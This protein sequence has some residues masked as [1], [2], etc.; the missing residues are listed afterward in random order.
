MDA[1]Y[2]IAAKQQ[3]VKDYNAA[4]NT[5]EA[6]R[7]LNNKVYSPIMRPINIHPDSEP[8]VVGYNKMLDEIIQD[9]TIMNIEIGAAAFDLRSFMSDTK[10][11]IDTVKRTIAEE[12]ERLADMTILCSRYSNTN[13]IKKIAPADFTGSFTINDKLI[14]NKILGQENV[15][16]TIDSIEGNGYEGNHHVYRNGAYLIDTINTS[17]RKFINDGSDITV[18]EYSR[19]TADNSEPEIFP[20]VNK[21]SLEAKCVISI[22]S[23]SLFDS[24]KIVSD[25]VGLK[26]TSIFVSDNGVSFNSVIQETYDLNDTSNRHDV[27]NYIP[28]SGIICFPSTKYVRISLES[29]GCV[30][31]TIAFEKSY[32]LNGILEEKTVQLKTGKRHIIKINDL[33]VMKTQYADTAS[34]VS[35]ELIEEPVSNIA[36]FCNE[37]IPPHISQADSLKYI[38]SVN[39]IDYE[40]VPINLDREGFKIVRTTEYNFSSEKIIYVTEK[41]KSVFLKIEMNTQDKSTSPIISNISLLVGGI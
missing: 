7:I 8:D 24:I 38:L 3:I 27:S 31:D 12:K 14:S 26:V 22:S 36:I 30:E 39:G 11:K 35:K 37:Y 19:I 34:L 4:G 25:S 13:A 21:D 18:Y 23:A 2:I 16:Y 6:N 28:G 17:D 41:I 33:L 5:E 15:S 29:S 10:L 40:V 32:D 9:V 1:K 20:L